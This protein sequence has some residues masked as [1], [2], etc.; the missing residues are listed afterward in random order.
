MDEWPILRRL[1]HDEVW[2]RAL[3]TLCSAGQKG[4]SIKHDQQNSTVLQLMLIQQSAKHFLEILQD[5]K[6]NLLEIL[7]IVLIAAEIVVMLY[8]IIHR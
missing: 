6:S 5:N 8:D 1:E 2:V 4:I 7:I 3:R